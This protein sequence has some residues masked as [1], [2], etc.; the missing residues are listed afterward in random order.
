MHLG[1]ISCCNL[2]TQGEIVPRLL[3]QW[4]IAPDGRLPLHDIKCRRPDPPLLESLSERIRVHERPT[5]CVNEDCGLLHLLEERFVH[6][7]VRLFPSGREDHDNVALLRDLVE[8]GAADLEEPVLRGEINLDVGTGGGR[9]IGSE[10]AVGDPET[11]ETG[12]HGLRDTAETYEADS[13][14]GRGGGG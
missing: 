1:K 6:N 11:S 9:G 5:S 4:V 3:D 2:R 14:V 10:E 8:L 7:V 13:A 12:K